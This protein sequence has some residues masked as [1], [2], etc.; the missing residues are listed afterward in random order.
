V[1]AE[2]AGVAGDG[3]AEDGLGKE[4][5]AAEPVR[6]DLSDEERPAA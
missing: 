6:Q 5:D 4:G 2:G 1:A 3:R